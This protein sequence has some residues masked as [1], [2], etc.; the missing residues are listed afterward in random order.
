MSI[1]DTPPNDARVVV[2]GDLDLDL[3]IPPQR[4]ARRRGGMSMIDNDNARV[5]GGD[6]EHNE[7]FLKYMKYF[8]LWLGQVLKRRYLAVLALQDNKTT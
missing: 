5:V 1:I 4:R 3:D 2:G 7:I 8:Y 6:L